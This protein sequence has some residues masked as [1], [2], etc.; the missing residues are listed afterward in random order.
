MGNAYAH[1][2]F[3]P[4][5][6]LKSRDRFSPCHYYSKWATTSTDIAGGNVIQRIPGIT[7]SETNNTARRIPM[8]KEDKRNLEEILFNQ[9]LRSMGLDFLKMY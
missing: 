2:C 7:M 3:C 8:T 4:P 5:T 9:Q 6:I 1:A